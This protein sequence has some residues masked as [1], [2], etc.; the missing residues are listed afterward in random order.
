[1][2]MEQTSFLFG[3]NAAFIQELYARYLQN[4]A[5]VDASWQSF[6]TELNDDQQSVLRDGLGPS[7]AKD[8]TKIIGVPED[9]A[10]VA[11][12]AN[13]KANGQ[14]APRPMARRRRRPVASP[15]SRC[16]PRRSIRCAP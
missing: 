1:M 9:G 7:W 10:P 3:A 2:R 11:G 16:A 13:G 8:G 4:P 15:P 12:K 14:A 6:F 5:A